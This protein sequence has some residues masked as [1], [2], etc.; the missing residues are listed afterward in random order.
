MKKISFKV[1][2][3]RKVKNDTTIEFEI[4][5]GKK[6]NVSQKA[7]G[8]LF[9]RL[10]KFLFHKINNKTTN[11]SK[12]K[13]NPIKFKS[14]EAKS[15]VL[16]LPESTITNAVQSEAIDKTNKNQDKNLFIS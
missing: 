9:F 14:V 12:K 3:N 15:S 11:S 5:K 10:K 7:V 6:I 2:S 13:P 16:N 1:Y 8:Y 4:L